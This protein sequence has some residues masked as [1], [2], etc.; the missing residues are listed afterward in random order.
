M[1][2][3]RRLDYNLHMHQPVL[4]HLPGYIVLHDY[5]QRPNQLLTFFSVGERNFPTDF[6]LSIAFNHCRILFE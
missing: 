3:H 2:L 1:Q 5:R 4:K 6:F